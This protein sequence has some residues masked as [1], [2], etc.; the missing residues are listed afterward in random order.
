MKNIILGII[1]GLVI[2]FGL[3]FLLKKKVY[4]NVDQQKILAAKLYKK[5]MIEEKKS[6]K[7]AIKLYKKIIRKC[8]ATYQR[9]M[10]TYRL[11]FIY[12]DRLKNMRKT[13]EIGKEYIENLSK[14][15]GSEIAY[16]MAEIYYRF[17]KR[18]KDAEKLYRKSMSLKKGLSWVLKSYQT[19][20][21]MYYEKGNLEEVIKMNSFLLKNF[22][23][24][25]DSDWYHILNLKCYWRL[26]K[27][28]KAYEEAKK[29]KD[30]NKIFVKNEILYWKVITNFEKENIR[31]LEMLGN[32]YFRMGFKDRARK[33]WRRAKILSSRSK[34][35]IEKK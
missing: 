6:L 7:Q 29:I 4:L 31:A 13:L 30:T 33:I 24:K 35:R 14:Y 27:I 9:E 12:K 20:S 16:Y 8:P 18:F 21:E 1:I 25:V 5:A 19:L 22:K 3:V 28:N 11:F 34:K 23:D 10:A 26:G 2:V 32:V 17:Y 15:R